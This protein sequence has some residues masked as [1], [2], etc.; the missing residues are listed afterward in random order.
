MKEKMGGSN[1]FQCSSNREEIR[2]LSLL[3]KTFTLETSEQARG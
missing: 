1:S 3:S 2:N